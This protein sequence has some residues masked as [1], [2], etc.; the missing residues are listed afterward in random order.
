MLTVPLTVQ[1]QAKEEQAYGAVNLRMSTASI[2]KWV[3]NSS[4]K[5]CC[6][7]FESHMWSQ[8]PPPLFFLFFYF[9][10]MSE[11]WFQ[12]QTMAPTRM[13]PSFSSRTPNSP[14]WI[15][16]TQCLES[17]SSFCW[18]SLDTAWCLQCYCCSHLTLLHPTQS[19]R[20][21]GNTGWTWKAACQWEDVP[22]AHWNSH[23]G[24]D[25]TCQSFCALTILKCA[26]G[27]SIEVVDCG[28]HSKVGE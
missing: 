4:R 14:T 21:L 16:S 3:T 22:A 8:P 25:D 26:G 1:A 27:S 23:Q 20:R 28:S 10:I 6:R 12:W 7:C 17:M 2:S 11:E 13:V 18:G 9:S 5:C 19:H 15:W 24:R